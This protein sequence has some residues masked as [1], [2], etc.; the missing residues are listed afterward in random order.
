MTIILDNMEQIKSTREA[1]FGPSEITLAHE[2]KNKPL[3][4]IQF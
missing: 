3:S 2:R 4:R 1:Q